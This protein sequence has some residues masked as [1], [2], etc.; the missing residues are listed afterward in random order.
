MALEH[1]PKIITSGLFVYYDPA[2]TR[3]YVGSGVTINNLFSGYGATFVNGPTYS[4]DNQ[5]YISFDGTNDYT[6]LTLPALTN[7]SFSFWIYN[8]T[9]PNS[10]EKQLLSTNGDITGLSMVLQKYII[11]N[12]TANY[13][14]ASVGQSVWTN[15]VY[16][17]NGFSSSAIYLNGVLDNSFATGNQIYSGAAQL[18]AINGTQRNTQAYLGSFMGYDKSLTAQEVLQNYNATKRRYGK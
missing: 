18:M 16:T 9:I 3:S 6:Q 13:G 5:G 14:N 10:F 12:G 7:W 11:W 2:N 17:N 15:V 4:S 8:H 1:H